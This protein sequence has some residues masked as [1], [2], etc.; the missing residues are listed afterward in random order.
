MKICLLGEFGGKNDEGYKNIAHNMSRQLSK[1]NDVLNINVKRMNQIQFW[2]QIREFK[3]DI[4]HYLTAPTLSSFAVLKTA[5]ILGN[6]DTKLVISSLH[7]YSLK[8]LKNPALKKIIPLIKPDIVLTQSNEVET[9]LRGMGCDTEFLPNGVDIER[10]T[11]VSV[12]IKQDLRDKYGIDREKFVILQ[13]GHIRRERGIKIFSKIQKEDKNNQVILVGSS[14]FKTDRKLYQELTNSG[15]IIWNRYFEEIEEIYA[16]SDC[17]VF[18]TAKG[19]SIFMPL[20]VL[21][22]MSS[23]IPVLSTRYEG[24]IDNFEEG[25]GLFFFENG[26]SLFIK[27]KEIRSEK[28]RNNNRKNVSL[29]SWEHV[30]KKLESIYNDLL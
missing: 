26:E 17:Y 4:I 27:L 7:P 10:F 2:N 3:P 21:E 12:E 8:L 11:P 28:F 6:K 22:A 18:P 1:K 5:K 16:L 25:N 14:Y 19:N 20:S 24:L 15:C 13:V 29:H 30:C 9:A 23:N